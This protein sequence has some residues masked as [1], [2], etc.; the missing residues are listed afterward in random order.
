MIRPTEESEQRAQ[1]WP[2]DDTGREYVELADLEALDG[3]EPGAPE[4]WVVVEA[5]EAL[6]LAAANL[7]LLA[8]LEASDEGPLR[9]A[10]CE[11]TAD[12][13]ARRFEGMDVD[14][15]DALAHWAE[16]AESRAVP[17]DEIVRTTET[18][19]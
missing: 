13:L 17:D 4:P 15:V 14:V 2:D 19:Q 7:D 11:T 12:R 10:E 8:E 9:M 6:A 5:G 16:D 3:V 1:E 18:L